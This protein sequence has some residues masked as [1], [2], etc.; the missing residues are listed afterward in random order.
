[1]YLV[2]LSMNTPEYRHPQQ[3]IRLMWKDIPSS[4]HQNYKR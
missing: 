4:Q 3:G 1:M 2:H